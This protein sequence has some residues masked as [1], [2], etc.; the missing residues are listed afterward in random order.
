MVQWWGPID[1]T[2]PDHPF[3]ATDSYRDEMG[4]RLCRRLVAFSDLVPPETLA[5]AKRR[6]NAL[7]AELADGG[8]RRVNLDVGYLD[9]NKLVLASV[10]PAGQKIHLG[11]GFYAELVARWKAGR[12]QPF[13]WAFPDFM[14]GRY[15]PELTTIRER[16]LEQLRQGTSSRS[17]LSGAVR[18]GLRA[19]MAEVD[20]Y[21][22]ER[23]IFQAKFGFGSWPALVVIDMAYGWTDPAYAGGSA[24]LDTAVA[25]LQRLLSAARQKGVPIFYT[26]APFWEKLPVKTAADFSPRF[27]KWDRRA[28]EI[29]ERVHPEPGERLIVKEHASAFAGTPLI[30]FLVQQRVDTLLITGCS[31]S[32]CVRATATDAKSLGLRPIIVREAVQDRAAPAHDWTLFDVQARFADVVGIDETLAYLG[33][34][35][36]QPHPDS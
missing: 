4:E 8:R 11:S 25:A 1:F 14:D 19:A 31:T 15:D 36:G 29:D 21:Y 13:E 7:E 3:D 32:A 9:H 2:G 35:L 10:K 6:C 20:A 33:S 22:R 30:G 28:V 23:G 27:R 16:Y 26:T 24:R 17:E 12:Y 34:L 18:E 5:D